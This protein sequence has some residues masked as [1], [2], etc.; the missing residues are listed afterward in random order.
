[1]TFSNNTE[2]FENIVG[3][4]LVKES[5]A[6]YVTLKFITLYEGPATGSYRIRMDRESPEVLNIVLLKVQVFGTV[7]LCRLVHTYRRFVVL[8]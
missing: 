8:Q 1:M 5:Y 2:F 7:T 6:I 3:A 4:Q